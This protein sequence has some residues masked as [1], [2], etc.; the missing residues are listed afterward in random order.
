MDERILCRYQCGA[1]DFPVM[2]YFLSLMHTYSSVW[3]VFAYV[4]SDK[5]DIDTNHQTDLT[6]PFMTVITNIPVMLNKQQRQP[7]DHELIKLG[8]QGEN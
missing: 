5:E 4:E 6:S 8:Q 2:I 3:I 7:Y 1:L